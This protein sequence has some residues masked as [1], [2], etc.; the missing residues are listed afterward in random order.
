MQESQRSRLWRRPP[1]ETRCS[2]AC[3][4][5]LLVDE[6]AITRAWCPRDV[7]AEALVRLEELR[8]ALSDDQRAAR[9]RALVADLEREEPRISRVEGD[10]D[11]I[12]VI[13]E[14]RIEQVRLKVAPDLAKLL[15]RGRAPRSRGA[16]P[17]PA[18]RA[19]EPAIRRSR[20]D[21]CSSANCR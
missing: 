14:R 10:V 18:R 8:R 7:V 20:R 6:E 16:R 4:C 19:P 11:G 13:D 1:G 2:M 5:I 17:V 12:Y 9:R 21:A 15:D 3:Q